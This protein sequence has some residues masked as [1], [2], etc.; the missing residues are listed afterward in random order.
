MMRVNPSKHRWFLVMFMFRHTGTLPEIQRSYH[1]K[2][3]M[4]AFMVW[5][6]IERKKLADQH[7]DLHNRSVSQSVTQTLTKSITK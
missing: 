1:V 2:R 3:P 7:P 4:N 5:S 6:Q